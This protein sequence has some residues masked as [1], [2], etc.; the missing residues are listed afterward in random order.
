MTNQ[1]LAQY[2][3]LSLYSATAVLTLAMVG[4]ALYL[5][6]LVP[7]RDQ[8]RA[9]AADVEARATEDE[10]RPQDDWIIHAPPVSCRRRKGRTAPARRR[11]SGAPHY[12]LRFVI[13][14]AASCTFLNSPSGS[15]TRPLPTR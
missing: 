2:S 13:S 6:G 15:G 3:N 8:K 7:H 9:T 11:G 1:T 5:A 10:E 14:L 4:Y 12:M